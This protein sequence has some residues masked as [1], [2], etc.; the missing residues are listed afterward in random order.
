MKVRVVTITHGYFDASF[1]ALLASL[2]AY[3]LRGGGSTR[4]LMKELVDLYESA[5]PIPNEMP[6]PKGE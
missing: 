1:V 2:K 6:G 4:V 3:E 5:M